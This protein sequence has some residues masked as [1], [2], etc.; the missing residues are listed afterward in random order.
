MS[1]P[2]PIIHPFLDACE[3]LTFHCGEGH[4]TTHREISLT[5][6]PGSQARKAARGLEL[7]SP[8]FDRVDYDGL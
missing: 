1:L 2:D 4:G 6:L 7:V 8:L 3:I 5:S